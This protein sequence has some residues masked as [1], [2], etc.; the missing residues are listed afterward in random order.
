MSSKSSKP[1]LLRG[2]ETIEG[3]LGENAGTFRTVCQIALEQNISLETENIGPLSDEFTQSFKRRLI[4]T[5]SSENSQD[6]L[7]DF[8]DEYMLPSEESL[9]DSSQNES[10]DHSNDE[11]PIQDDTGD[12]TFDSS[13][14]KE[15]ECE[16]TV[17]LE[18]ESAMS[19]IENTAISWLN[20]PAVA[21]K[22]GRMDILRLCISTGWDLELFRDLENRTLISEAL[23]NA[24]PSYE[25]ILLL[26]EHIDVNIQ[27]CR[28]GCYSF[29]C[30]F[31]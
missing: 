24:N 30:L 8:V 19:V 27:V 1:F 16:E 31:V 29:T 23:A 9:A 18:N 4:N 5:A 17:S 3:F 7:V 25:L 21:V 12:G 2:E 11:A 20:I 15:N 26:L 13:K 28:Q 22:E 14:D 6:I 10:R